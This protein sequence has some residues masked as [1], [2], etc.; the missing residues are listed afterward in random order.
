MTAAEPR[1]PVSGPP[2][3][4]VIIPKLG[5]SPQDISG[6]SSGPYSSYAMIPVSSIPGRDK[7]AYL[8]RR[9]V[10]R[11]QSSNNDRGGLFCHKC[12]PNVGSTVPL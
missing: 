7:S 10:P 5:A 3:K 8:S 11:A 4:V 2:A 6:P 1:T 9:L 12:V